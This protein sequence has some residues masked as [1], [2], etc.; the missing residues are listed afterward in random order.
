METL[1]ERMKWAREQR[2]M[3]QPALAHALGVAPMTVSKWERGVMDLGSS[4]LRKVS[5]LLGVSA[6]WLLNGGPLEGEAV[7]VAEVPFWDEFLANYGRVSEL[8]DEELWDIRGFAARRTRP[9]SWSDLALIAEIVLRDHPSR[10]FEGKG[11]S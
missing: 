4:K 7:R 5:A 8:S 9:R 6:D 11:G 10:H 2:S 1:G 3:S